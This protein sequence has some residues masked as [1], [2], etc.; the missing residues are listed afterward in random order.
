M[1]AG[2]SSL[3]LNISAYTDPG[4]VRPTNQDWWGQFIPPDRHMLAAKGALFV[5]ADGMGG[6]AGGQV[7][8]QLAV[9]HLLQA[10]YHDPMR[11]LE[12]SLV[13]AIR[14]ANQQVYRYG[15]YYPA[16]QGMATT[17]VAAVI[18]D[19][20]LIVAHVGDSRAYLAR[21]GRFWPLTRDHSW[22]AEMVARGALTPAEAANHPY[23]HV[24]SRSVGPHPD[25]QVDV[26]RMRLFAGDTLVLCTDGLSDL[27]TPA[28]IGWAAATLPP[29][30]ATHTLVDWANQRGG[31]DNISALVVRAEQ[32]ARHT[33]RLGSALVGPQISAAHPGAGC[34][35]L[36][37]S[38]DIASFLLAA[39]IVVAGMALALV[40]LAS[41]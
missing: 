34:P 6:R 41:M 13:Q 26:R 14:V 39:G 23:R 24:I 28:E 30:Q 18:R 15:Q 31:R 10:Y 38:G 21:A 29:H 37:P 12:K 7:A 25:V 20:E 22:V 1:P 4:R 17:L 3:Q 35:A 5:V 16:Y 9:Q 19:Q 33:S 36:A 2:T 11:S 27:V 40:L 8:S 32:P